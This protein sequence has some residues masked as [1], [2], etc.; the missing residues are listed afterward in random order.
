MSRRSIYTTSIHTTHLDTGQLRLMIHVNLAACSCSVFIA[1]HEVV[2]TCIPHS[3]Y[4]GFIAVCCHMPGH[5]FI[6]EFWGWRL[7]EGLLLWLWLTA[8]SYLHMQSYTL[9]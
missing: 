9:P 6:E 3:A 8:G 2:S 7:G 4:F 1:S 5:Y